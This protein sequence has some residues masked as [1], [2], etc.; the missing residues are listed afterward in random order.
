MATKAH[1]A[2]CFETL[3]ASF[4]RRQA[5]SLAQV[6]QLW[7]ECYN[8]NGQDDGDEASSPSVQPAAISRLLS[9]ATST[10]S[11]S[12]TLTSTTS[13]TQTGK[14][15]PATSQSSSRSSLVS[16]S[17]EKRPL[18][19]TWNTISPSGNKSLRGCIGTFEPQ[20]LEDGLSSYAMTSAFDDHRFS[21]IPKEL[22]PRLQCAVT[23]LINFS[24]P[25]KD[26]M[27][28]TI[29]THG[30][31]ISFTYHGRRLGATYLPDVALEQGWTK[32]EA[33]VSLMRKAGWSGKKEEWRKVLGLEL[34]RYEGKKVSL[35]YK[36]WKEWRDWVNKKGI[37]PTS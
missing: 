9:R 25:T 4:E 36:E 6:E 12:S 2:F 37:K 8:D 13:S 20:L 14:S 29:G 7:D 1:C 22:M 5:L 19:I 33:I 23:L 30:I 16:T 27:D 24:S 10:N 35:D 3:A 31:R 11:S 28:W 34:V 15:T 32:E 26:P 18:F 21:P 17:G